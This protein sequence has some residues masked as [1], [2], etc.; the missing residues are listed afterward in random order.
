MLCLRCPCLLSLLHASSPKGASAHVMHAVLLCLVCPLASC[1]V[2]VVVRMLAC[3]CTTRARAC[4]CCG[5]G[6]WA[7]SYF[8]GLS[9]AL[10]LRRP[11]WLACASPSHLCSFPWH[12]KS[13]P[14]NDVQQKGPTERQMKGGSVKGWTILKPALTEPSPWVAITTKGSASKNPLSASF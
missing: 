8:P 6:G 12:P 4:L 9:V 3:L 11:G 14:A 10:W 13:A 2:M 5:C 1:P 7:R